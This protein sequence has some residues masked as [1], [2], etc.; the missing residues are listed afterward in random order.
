MK[1]YEI[2]IL[3]SPDLSEEEINLFREKAI[4][5]ITA[6]AGNLIEAKGTKRLR[7]G[8]PVKKKREAY[9]LTFIFSLEGEKLKLLEEKLKAEPTVLRYLMAV[10]KPVRELVIKARPLVPREIPSEIP[11]ETPRI[12]KKVELK[13]IEEKLEE[14]LNQ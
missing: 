4:S 8:Q 3:V 7:L 12:E 9:F 2:S 6:E 1:N 10:K 13:E 11:K 5:F 14:I